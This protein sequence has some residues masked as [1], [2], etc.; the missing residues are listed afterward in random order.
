MKL[1][2]FSPAALVGRV[3]ASR[4]VVTDVIGEGGM[5]CVLEGHCIETGQQVAIKVLNTAA[6]NP[7]NLRRFRRECQAAAALSHPNLCP[8]YGYG[9]LA[10]GAPYIAMARLHGETLSSRLRAC[11]PLDVGDTVSI[12]LQLLS[13]L[14]AAHAIG[15]LHRDVKPGNI[16][17]TSGRGQLPSV[18]LID[19]GLAK[20]LPSC[21][22]A[23]FGEETITLTNVDMIPGTP[24]YLSPE[25]IRSGGDVDERIDVWAAGVTIHEMLTGKKPFRA[26]TR[27]ELMA[28]IMFDEIAP[29]RD[30]RPDVPEELAAVLH[31]AVAKNRS[32]R[33]RTTADLRRELL[34]AWSNHR[35]RGIARGRALGVGH[36]TA[37]VARS[38]RRLTASTPVRD[39]LPTLP[40]GDRTG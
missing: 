34:L 39:M 17:L 3:L 31:D 32:E 5:G 21:S 13:A 23:G 1:R 6:F 10:G 16:F 12:S 29:I 30:A 26:L 20:P 37:P 28:R 40:L 35:A 27:E 33:F 9:T 19:F 7:V 36:T 24:H 2:R 22:L 4:Y 8:V 18:K 11:G 25:Q 38:E 14:S 15:V